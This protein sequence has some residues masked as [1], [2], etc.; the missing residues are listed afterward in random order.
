MVWR[1]DNK[2]TMLIVLFSSNKNFSKK[3][4]E[5]SLECDAGDRPDAGDPAQLLGIQHDE[6][7]P[8]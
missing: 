7:R 4:E 1:G 2:A 8:D 6:P 3:L 5:K